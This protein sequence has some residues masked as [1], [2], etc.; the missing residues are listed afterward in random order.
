MIAERQLFEAKADGIAH[1]QLFDAWEKPLFDRDLETVYRP[2]RTAKSQESF[3]RRPH[4]ENKSLPYI[5]KENDEEEN[6]YIICDVNL[7]G[8]TGGFPVKARDKLGN[9]LYD[10]GKALYRSYT[11]QESRFDD[12]I[13]NQG[14]FKVGERDIFLSYFKEFTGSGDPASFSTDAYTWSNGDAASHALLFTTQ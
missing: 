9:V 11:E 2:Y 4:P 1:V 12:A 14:A 10:N 8:E 7:H 6:D 13:G 3:K 5:L